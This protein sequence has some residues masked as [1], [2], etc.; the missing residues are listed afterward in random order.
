M[1]NIIFA[2]TTTVIKNVSTC[3][4]KFL[5]KAQKMLKYKHNIRYAATRQYRLVLCKYYEQGIG[6]FQNHGV[7]IFASVRFVIL[8]IREMRKTKRTLG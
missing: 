2:L 6:M 7:V 8:I 1:N 3:L 4:E 5:G